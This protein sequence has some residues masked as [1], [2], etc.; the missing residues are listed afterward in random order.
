MGYY[1]YL[2]TLIASVIISGAAAIYLWHRH[3]APGARATAILM[4]LILIWSAGYIVEVL[5]STLA[6]QHLANS[7]EYI[8]IVG[9]PVM[10][11]IVSIQ[12]TRFDT[13]LNRHLYVLFIIPLVL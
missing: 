3:P 8:G 9:I 2:L 10:W 11:F 5:T 6:G 1:E 4:L 12:Y 7:I 13:W